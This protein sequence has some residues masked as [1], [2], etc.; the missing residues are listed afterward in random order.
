VRLSTIRSIPGAW[1]S[2]PPTASW[3][4]V[5]RLA[6]LPVSWPPGGDEITPP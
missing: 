3:S 5:E 2:M 1:R 6:F 4:R